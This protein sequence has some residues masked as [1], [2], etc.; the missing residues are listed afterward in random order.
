MQLLLSHHE[1]D[2]AIS[3]IMKGFS[4]HILPALNRD[5]VG[6]NA[7][8]DCQSQAGSLN[9]GGVDLMENFSPASQQA[10]PEA[11]RVMTWMDQRKFLFS[12]N[13]LGSDENVIVPDINATAFQLD[14][15]YSILI[16]ALG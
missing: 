2:D 14:R 11:Q 4:I 8:G 5:G 12:I 9:Q 10:Q 1:L 15:R 7:P 6:L 13:L 3:R 16:A